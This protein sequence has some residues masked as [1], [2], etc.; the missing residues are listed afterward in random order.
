QNEVRIRR[1]SPT[2][3]SEILQSDVEGPVSFKLRSIPYHGKLSEF[4]SSVS[5]SFVNAIDPPS[6]TSTFT[7]QNFYSAILTWQ[8]LDNEQF[9][10]GFR[11]AY[12]GSFY[13]YFLTNLLP[14]TSHQY[15]LSTYPGDQTVYFILSIADDGSY[16]GLQPNTQRLNINTPSLADVTSLTAT[17]S[18]SPIKTDL[19]W[20]NITGNDSWYNGYIVERAL[21]SGTTVGSYQQIGVISNITSN[22]YSDLSAVSKTTYT[23]KL[24]SFAVRSQ[25][26]DTSKSS[27]VI[28][29]ATLP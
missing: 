6:S 10:S 8:T 3:T 7:F 28:V 24:R 17:V 2:I 19:N 1:Y 21:G 27:G 4:S 22:S 29:V 13:W 26:A 11:I 5:S 14:S 18:S 20:I 16:N 12:L 9:L 23:Y 25:S 15:T